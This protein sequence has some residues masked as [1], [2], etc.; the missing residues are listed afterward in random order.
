MS[1]IN[2]VGGSGY[3]QKAYAKA[4][5]KPADAAAASAGK[6]GKASDKLELSHVNHLLGQLKTNDVRLDKITDIKAQIAA[7]TYETDDK[8]DGAAEKLLDDV[9]A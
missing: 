8:L 9:A 4:T 6:A 5:P 3:I 2:S 1:S 7:G